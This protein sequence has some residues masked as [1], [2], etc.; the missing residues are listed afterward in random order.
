M[1]HTMLMCLL[2]CTSVPCAAQITSQ[3]TDLSAGS[4]SGSGTPGVA[5]VPLRITGNA[6][7]RIDGRDDDEI[8]RNAV[9]VIAFRQMDPREDG[10]PSMR[11]E[12]RFA[13]DAHNLYAVVRN[14]DP[15]PD[16]I[17]SV[18]ERRDG[19]SNSDEVILGV[20]SYHDRRTAYMF[21]LTP[22]G[23]MS[24]G[25]MY[26]DGH[27]E[28]WDWNAVWEGAAGIDSL[29]W[30][31]EFRIPLSQLRYVAA[32][33]N[34]FGL[35]VLRTIARR[36]ERLTWPLLRK[37]G[38]GSV[39]QMAATSGFA[40]LASPRR[41]EL[42]PYSMARYGASPRADGSFR[43]AG[44]AQIGAD[45]KLGLTPNITLDAAVNPDFGQVEADPGVLNLSAFEQYYA[46]QRPFFLEGIGIY[47][48]DTDCDDGTCSGLFY[49]RRIGRTPQLRA[50]YGD[51]ASPL[52]TQIMGAA[53]LTGRLG[54]GLSVGFLDAVTA[55]ET[56]SQSRTI[57][58]ATNYSV[59]RVQQ[60]L[61]DG[62]STLGFMLTGTARATDEWTGPL[63][64]RDAWSGGVDARHRFAQN[65]WEVQGKLAGSWVSG[66]AESIT[67]TQM[68]A[69]HMYQR[70][71][72]TH[73]RVDSSLTHMGGFL[74]QAAL[75]KLG[76]GA[77]RFQANLSYVDPGFEIND[78][79]FKARADDIAWSIWTGV[80]PVRP[81]GIFR[82]S[83][84]NFNAWGNSN[85]IGMMTGNGGNVNG[86]GQFRNFW[87]ANAGIGVNNIGRTYSDRN[88]RG[89][90]VLYNPPRATVWIGGNGDARR[91]FTPNAGLTL[92]RYFDGSGSGWNVSGGA[93]LRVGTQFNAS[94]NLGY[95]RAINDQQWNG[96]FST[97]SG[98][99]YTFARLYQS[100]GSVTGRV[101]YTVTPTLSLESY[102]QPF[103][104]TGHFTDWREIA[105]GRASER[106]KRFRPFSSQGEP[107]GFRFGQ[108]RANTVLRWEYRPGSTLFLVWTQSRDD[109][110]DGGTAQGVWQGYSSVFS[111]HPDNIFLVKLSYW[112][113]R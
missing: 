8:W 55:R 58:P 4:N 47:R 112:L 14:F 35:L 94:L 92:N 41:S 103:V 2:L 5:P 33:D 16:S 17:I 50:S 102:I 104:S 96:N 51:A 15:H 13:Y 80:Q 65:R 24:D 71:D 70:S 105:D 42:L 29:G 88:A 39:S 84:L 6:A 28:D 25:Y 52:Q 75:A 90:P 86:W 11:T 111:R 74:A 108:V 73:V 44:D 54:S 82:S 72:A 63:L 40:G 106:E 57:E 38:S 56:G 12:A 27:S 21:R 109:G 22:A 3:S 78:L 113:G 95:S 83:N 64:R 9:P 48:Y 85:T 91:A 1:R 30:V 20:D 67:L 45:V 81:V 60:D 32:D 79:G 87:S 97:E 31:A 93:R 59:L 68:S 36:G 19:S 98:T 100:T 43:N 62:G 77:I 7:P 101:N 89:G 34:T 53:K 110:D 10:D 69:V 61:R 37:S 18:L 107:G 46:E 76:G 23:T 66:S 99:A 49:S 26:G